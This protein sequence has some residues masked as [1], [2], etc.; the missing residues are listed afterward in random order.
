MSLCNYKDT[1]YIQ[2]PKQYPDKEHYSKNAADTTFKEKIAD[3]NRFKLNRII[4]SAPNCM[5]YQQESLIK[6]ERDAKRGLEY[7]GD[8][9]E[10]YGRNAIPDTTSGLDLSLTG[11]G[12]D[13]K[14]D[15]S[16]LSLWAFCCHCKLGDY[17]KGF[18]E[19]KEGIRRFIWAEG[20]ECEDGVKFEDVVESKVWKY[21]H[22]M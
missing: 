22:L 6:D 13:V 11:I 3:V 18:G 9:R 15:A 17:E 12:Y 5:K 2:V 7:V 16:I 1:V 4:Y 20:R 8:A 21:G 10:L 14:K 19:L